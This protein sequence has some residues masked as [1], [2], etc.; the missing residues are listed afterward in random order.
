MPAMG[1]SVWRAKHKTVGYKTPPKIFAFTPGN[2]ADYTGRAEIRAALS[3]DDFA[4]VGFAYR[5]AG[6]EEWTKLGVDDNA[7][8]RVF[9]DVSGLA[10][11]T[12]VEYR[13]VAKDIRDHY[14]ATSSWGIVGSPGTAQ[15]DPGGGGGPVVQPD[16]ASIPGDHNSEMGCSADWLPGCDQAQLT[17][18]LKDDIWR[19]TV[20]VPAGNYAYKVA[21]DK[22]WD[23]NYGLG[24]A[25]NGGN[26]GYTA[27]GT[28]VRFYYDHRTHNIGNSAQGPVIAAA[29]SFQSEQG[30]PADWSP[31]CLRAW[32]GDPD[33]DGTYTWAGT[34]IPKGDY[35][36]K[37]ALNETWDE[38]YGE[39]G[40]PNGTNIKFSVPS[41]GLTVQ[42]SY[43]EATHTPSVSSPNRPPR[44]T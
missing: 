25:L 6:T 32:L 4:Q 13:M 29:G 23:V 2:G 26:I 8:Y 41:D 1:V 36:F 20:T 40:T 16:N 14:S 31:D 12:M 37:I 33:G 7:P 18:D 43:D 11:G 19:T 24:G 9:H 30:C 10:K 3:T 42:F 15:E 22:T 39:G 17:R 38:N 44:P 28:P 34:A 5:V 21:I 27:P 35:E